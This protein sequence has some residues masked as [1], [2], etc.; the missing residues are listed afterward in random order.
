MVG[1]GINKQ[2]TGIDRPHDGDQFI[3]YNFD[4][5]LARFHRV[6]HLGTHGLLHDA[7][8]EIPHHIVMHIGFQQGVAN[9]FHGL[10][11]IGLTDPAAPGEIPKQI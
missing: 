3:E 8:G 10:A 6:K 5:L 9:L 1:G 4:H 11:D 2:Q 7:G